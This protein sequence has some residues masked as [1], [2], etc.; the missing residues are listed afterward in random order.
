MRKYGSP[1]LCGSTAGMT[2]R[3]DSSVRSAI[4]FDAKSGAERT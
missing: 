2:T 3:M 1:A 4:M